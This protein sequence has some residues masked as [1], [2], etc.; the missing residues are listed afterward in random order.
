[1]KTQPLKGFGGVIRA[2]ASLYL[3]VVPFVIYVCVYGRLD[4][5]VL[6]LDL[7]VRALRLDGRF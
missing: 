7:S 2:T 4:M 3:S 5:P 1:M 6:H